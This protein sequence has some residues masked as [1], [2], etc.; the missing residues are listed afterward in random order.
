MI[1]GIAATP[2]VQGSQGVATTL[3]LPSQP[4]ASGL[5]GSG[6]SAALAEAAR[7]AAAT[8]QAG[9]AAA[10]AGVQGQLAPQ[11]VVEQVLAAERTLQTVLAVRDKLVGAYLE[12]NR[13]QI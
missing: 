11:R 7:T 5:E 6:F 3:R 9:E 1:G 12:I 8:L 13:M 2:G 4:G 10:M